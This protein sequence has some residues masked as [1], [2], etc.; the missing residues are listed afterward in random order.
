MSTDRITGTPLVLAPKADTDPALGKD[1]QRNNKFDYNPSSQKLCP[2]A[3]HSRKTNPRSDIR[4]DVSKN[5]IVRRAIAFGPELTAGEIK[6][7]KTVDD[8]GLLFKCYQSNI[9]N[10]FE[11]IQQ[12]TLL[13]LCGIL[14]D[15]ANHQT[16]VGQTVPHFRSSNLGPM[17][18]LCQSPDSRI[19]MA[20][21]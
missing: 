17:A 5:R 1:P 11:F 21:V 19:S 9:A 4:T 16:Q 6:S 20:Q 13:I 10:G 15:R 7:R 2:Y 8:R 12:S 3:A 14:L 18:Y